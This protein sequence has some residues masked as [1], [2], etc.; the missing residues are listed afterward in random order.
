MRHLA[1][2]YPKVAIVPL[3]IT[4]LGALF[5]SLKIFLEGKL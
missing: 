3:Q 2:P 1:K 4:S 5:Y